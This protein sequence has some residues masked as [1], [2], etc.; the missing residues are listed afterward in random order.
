MKQSQKTA[1]S[2][3]MF[4]GLKKHIFLSVPLLLYVLSDID[5]RLVG[6]ALLVSLLVYVSLLIALSL[7]LE[8][9]GISLLQARIIRF[10]SALAWGGICFLAYA[11][12]GVF[13]YVYLWPDV[14]K[15]PPPQNYAESR[16]EAPSGWAVMEQSGGYDPEGEADKTVEHPPGSGVAEQR[17]HQTTSQT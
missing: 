13:V 7:F 4:G 9:Q 16:W 15:R 6:Y 8:E 1:V 17:S 3:F 2:T 10:V 14:P 12:I 5:A 11:T